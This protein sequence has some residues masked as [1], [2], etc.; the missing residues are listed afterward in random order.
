MFVLLDDQA[1]HRQLYFTD[2]VEVI[3]PSFGGA[4]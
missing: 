1:T 4:R 2:P 3:T